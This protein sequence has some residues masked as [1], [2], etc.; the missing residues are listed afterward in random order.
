MGVLPSVRLALFQSLKEA[1]SLTSSQESLW[2]RKE[3]SLLLHTCQVDTAP[4]HVFE[5]VFSFHQSDWNWCTS[6]VL[7]CSR[8]ITHQTPDLS[9]KFFVCRWQHCLF[10]LN[11]WVFS[12]LINSSDGASWRRIHLIPDTNGPLWCSL[13]TDL[14]SNCSPWQ[15]ATLSAAHSFTESLIYSI[16]I[17]Q[18]SVTLGGRSSIRCIEY[19]CDEADATSASGSLLSGMKEITVKA[20]TVE[21]QYSWQIR[22][23]GNVCEDMGGLRRG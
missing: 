14:M 11:T 6:W 5:I 12:L 19:S 17:D 1:D 18:V 3:T 13:D 23:L 10:S 7:L 16:N 9:H 15:Q 2:A 22:Q 20:L 4:S 21:A 8:E